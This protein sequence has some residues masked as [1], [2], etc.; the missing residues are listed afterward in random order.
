ML[1]L[2]PAVFILPG[3]EACQLPGLHNRITASRTGA[4]PCFH[5]MA[6][7]FPRRGEHDAPAMAVCLELRPQLHRGATAMPVRAEPAAGGGHYRFG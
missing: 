5:L 3:E 1:K 6:K 7:I 2:I 4:A